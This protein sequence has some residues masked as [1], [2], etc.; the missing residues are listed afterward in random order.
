MASRSH[1]TQPAAARCPTARRARRREWCQPRSARG[2]QVYVSQADPPPQASGVVR[3]RR[4][5]GPSPCLNRRTI[6][7][8]LETRDA[9][10]VLARKQGI[11][12]PL[13][14]CS[15][16][17]SMAGSPS[18]RPPNAYLVRDSRQ[19][20]RRGWPRLGSPRPTACVTGAYAV[21]TRSPRSQPSL[22]WRTCATIWLQRTRVQLPRP[23]SRRKQQRWRRQQIQWH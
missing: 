1:L 12:Q 22:D 18:I 13:R 20:E 2:N 19:Q 10:L 5:P 23:R 11:P 14:P 17:A 15:Q 8:R 4:P 21:R 6:S 16:P 3:G 7:G 9:G